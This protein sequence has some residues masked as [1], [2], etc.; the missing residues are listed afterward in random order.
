MLLVI[1]LT[2]S[3]QVKVSNQHNVHVNANR[4][5]TVPPSLMCDFHKLLC[6][7]QNNEEKLQ[8]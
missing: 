1:L 7:V 2:H 4:C 6:A 5:T 3:P 8:S